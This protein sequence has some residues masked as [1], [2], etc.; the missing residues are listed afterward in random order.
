MSVEIKLFS[1]FKD[2]NI[3]QVIKFMATDFTYYSQLPPQKESNINQPCLWFDDLI[4]INEPYRFKENFLK[5]AEDNN[6]LSGGATDYSDLSYTYFST[7][8]IDGKKDEFTATYLDF[9]KSIV[10]LQVGISKVLISEKIE[11]CQTQEHTKIVI[12]NIINRLQFLIAQL[13]KR[14]NLPI[15]AFESIPL[16]LYALLRYLQEAHGSFL[17][18]PLPVIFAEAQNPMIEQFSNLYDPPEDIIKTIAATNCTE[19]ILADKDVLPLANNEKET[20]ESNKILSRRDQEAL[21]FGN[22]KSIIKI[23]SFSWIR[24]AES[25]TLHLYEILVEQKAIYKEETDF[26]LFCLAFNGEEVKQQLGIKWHL[27]S[28][29]K[30]TKAPILRM[31]DQLINELFLINKIESDGDFARLIEKIFVDKH[32]N[33]LIAV[34]STK[35]EIG[36]SRSIEEKQLYESLKKLGKLIQ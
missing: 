13:K 6:K 34:H 36:K 17:P 26:N 12:N 8:E 4:N 16:G 2:V 11:S 10:K 14:R 20:S 30:S 29:H 27:K 9:I 21:S 23:K 5:V 19:S 32:G 3:P 31:F 22:K 15:R 35:I 25:L 7:Y 28:T 18:D 24:N 33:N 1:S